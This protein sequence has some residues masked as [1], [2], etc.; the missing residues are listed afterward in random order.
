[1]PIF[2]FVLFVFVIAFMIAGVKIV[3]QKQEMIIERLGKYQKT[4]EPGLNWIVPVSD[5][6]RPIRVK[7]IVRTIS[8]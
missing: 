7:K 3:N 2:L 5:V 6:A 8:L 1:M 4:L